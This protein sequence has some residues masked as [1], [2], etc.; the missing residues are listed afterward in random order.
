MNMFKSV[1]AAIAL[2]GMGTAANA[3]VVLSDNFDS[4]TNGNLSSQGGWTATAVP[5]TPNAMQVAG[6]TDKFVQLNTIGGQDEYKAFTS[7][8]AHT[9]GNSILTSFTANIASAAVAGDYFAHLSSP[10]ATT[11]LFFQRVFARSS[12]AGFQLGLLDTSGTGSAITWGSTEL[13]FGT[14][15]DVDVTWNFVAGAVNDTFALTVNNAAYLTHAWTSVNGEPATIEAANLRQGGATTSASVQ[16]DD[17]VI[18]EVVPEPTSLA[19]L[20]LGAMGL[21]HRRRNRC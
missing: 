6:A 16:F 9:D 2:A 1:A 18:T 17:Y 11:S 10:L 8:V 15:Y 12:G 3:A 19:A 14:E 21:L 5:V 20:G 7:V 13:T 4:Y